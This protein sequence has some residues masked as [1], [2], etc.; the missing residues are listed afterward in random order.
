MATVSPSLSYDPRFPESDGVPLESGWHRDQINL[1]VNLTRYQFRH[2]DD[3][4]VAGNMF[5]YY[6]PNDPRKAVGPDYFYVDGVSRVPRRR[7]WA[8][9]QEDNRYPDTIIELMSPKTKHKDRKTNKAIYEKVFRTPEYFLYDPETEVLDG[10]RLVGDEYETIV[11]NDEGW[12]W[13]EGLNLW[14][15]TWQGILENEGEE[16]LWLRFY[17]RDGRLVPLLS[18]AERDEAEE[19]RQRA[20]A[21]EAELARLRALLQQQNPPQG[22]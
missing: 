5:I 19:E 11:P 15:G 9:W 18:E 8:V 17:E 1:L 22:D 21:A 20:E 4:H 13:S 3:F 16:G 2:R 10:W 7:I 12:M 14:V 6:D